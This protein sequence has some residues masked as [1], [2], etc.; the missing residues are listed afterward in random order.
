MA[1]FDV[2]D[3]VKADSIL[4][5]VPTYL[6]K[7]EKGHCTAVICVCLLLCVAVVCLFVLL[8]CYRQTSRAQYV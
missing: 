8:Q 4:M 7:L 1:L 2:F 5:K 3:F 6:H